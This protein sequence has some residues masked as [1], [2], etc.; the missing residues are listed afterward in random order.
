MEVCVK[1]RKIAYDNWC[2]N[3]S[4]RENIVTVGEKETNEYNA[5]PYGIKRAQYLNEYCDKERIKI[6]RKKKESNKPAGEKLNIAPICLLVIAV[7]FIIGV[8]VFICSHPIPK[9][10]NSSTVQSTIANSK[11]CQS[12]G[13]SFTDSKNTM[14]IAK[15]HM[16]SNCYSNF[17][18]GME[19]TGKW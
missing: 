3:C 9:T 4:S 8:V 11:T 15:T 18:W 1:C 6:E 13:R 17:E 5:L 7:G 14:S 10:N 12:C 19:A 16:C 2:K